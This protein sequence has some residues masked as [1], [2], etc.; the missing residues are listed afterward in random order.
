MIGRRRGFTL[1]EILL[2]VVLVGF[3]AAIS[4]ARL[5]PQDPDPLV[6]LNRYLAQARSIALDGGPLFLSVQE[7]ALSLSDASG[8]PV[9][10]G[11]HLPQGE[12]HLFPERLIFFRDGSCSPGTVKLDGGWGRDSFLLAVTGH[13][14]QV[15]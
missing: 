4:V 7:G 15:R 5:A 13:V 3:L 8:N 6:S 9:P 14:Y 12:W 2:V 10:I 1:F 11:T